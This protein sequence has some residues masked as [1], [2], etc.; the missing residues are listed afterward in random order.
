M[1]S[2]VERI[3]PNA[4]GWESTAKRVEGTALQHLTNRQQAK[5]SLAAMAQEMRRGEIRNAADAQARNPRDKSAPER[6]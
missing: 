5:P 4:L 2:E 6:C 1:Q 3:A